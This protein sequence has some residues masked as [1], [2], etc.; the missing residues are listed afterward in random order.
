M[1][2]SSSPLLVTATASAAAVT[3]ILLYRRSSPT[4]P[5]WYHDLLTG[6][7]RLR[8][9]EWENGWLWRLRNGW[10]GNDY[11]HGPAA[12]VRIVGYVLSGA[13]VGTK[14]VGAAHYT[15]NAESH[16]GLCHGGSM[17]SVMDD[18]IGWVGFCVTGQCV[19]WCGFTVT[20]NVSLKNPVPVGSWLRVEGVIT[21]V[22]RR[23]VHVKASLVAP[24]CNG[25]DEKVHC[26]A[27]GLFI[28]KK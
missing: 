1:P 28:L 11:V 8:V 14:L 24:A 7:K 9:A 27:D 21:A 26:T 12:G 17:T 2:L 18:V 19:P 15:A 3:A 25:E 23:K 10:M 20:V 16:K 22:E 13:G 5:Q 4:P 6:A